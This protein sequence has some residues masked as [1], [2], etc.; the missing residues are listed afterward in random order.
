MPCGESQNSNKSKFIALKKIFLVLILLLSV[1]FFTLIF[2][3]TAV[4][5]ISELAGVMLV[6]LLYL[7]YLVYDNTET[8]K[9]RFALPVYLILFATLLSFIG[10]YSFHGQSFAL[11]LKGQAY[12]FF[13]FIYFLLNKFKIE[14]A[15]LL[16]TILVLGVV[17]MITYISQNILYPVK[18]VSYPMFI[19][20]GTLRIFMPGAGYMVLGYFIS[21][22]LYFRDKKL[23]YI[24]YMLMAVTTFVLLGTRQVIASVGLI[25]IIYTLRSNLIKRKILLYFMIILGAISVYF[26]FQDIFEAMFSLT[27]KQ[28]ESVETNIRYLAAKFFLTD[29]FQSP[30]AYFT[31]NGEAS[32]GSLYSLQIIRY[33]EQ[34]GYFQSDIGLFGDFSKYG[35]F[36]ILG[37]IMLI[38]RVFSSK[39]PSYLMFI[40]YNMASLVLTMFTAGS[41]FASSQN[42]VILCL[43]YYLIDF[44]YNNEDYRP[45]EEK[46]KKEK[47]KPG[48]QWEVRT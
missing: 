36:F 23:I 17:Y 27:E 6:V 5:R 33:S 13:Y 7:I 38:V 43:T 44:H 28:S 15:F 24:L 32:G 1:E 31:G 4:V 9:T 26:L 47:K 37:V 22:H 11:T 41:S 14:P 3:P 45:E 42:L 12:M 8:W 19:D 25:T 20:R 30:L 39:I 21:L 34:Y 2:V 48:V 29:F 18:L 16:K 10:A 40:K 35:F 46:T